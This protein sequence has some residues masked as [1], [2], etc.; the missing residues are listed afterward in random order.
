MTLLNPTRRSVPFGATGSRALRRLK[1][2]NGR[3]GV[4]E[5]DLRCMRVSSPLHCTFSAFN[6]HTEA[7]DRTDPTDNRPRREYWFRRTGNGDDGRM[8]NE[9]SVAVNPANG[10]AAQPT[11]QVDSLDATSQV[12]GQASN[13]PVSNTSPNNHPCRSDRIRPMAKSGEMAIPYPVSFPWGCSMCKTSATAQQGIQKHASSVHSLKA[14]F[15]CE[16]AGCKRQGMTGTFHSIA[17]HYPKCT[18]LPESSGAFHCEDCEATYQTKRGLSQHVRHRHPIQCNERRKG[19]AEREAERKRCKRRGEQF[20]DELDRNARARERTT[21]ESPGEQDSSMEARETVGSP[22]DR[23]LPL[24]DIPPPRATPALS[25]AEKLR[26]GKGSEVL[27]GEDWEL[28]L[29]SLAEDNLTDD[30]RMVE[31]CCER[32]LAL[33]PR[34]PSAKPKSRKDR[35]IDKGTEGKRVKKSAVFRRTQQLFEKN[36]AGL[37]REILDGKCMASCSLPPEEVEKLYET[38][39]S[40]PGPTVDLHQWPEP[41]RKDDSQLMTYISPNM[42]RNQIGRLKTSSASGPDGIRKTDLLKWDRYGYK[43]SALFNCWLRYQKVPAILKQNRSILI[44]KT[45]E[46]LDAIGNWRPL[47]IGPLPLRIFSSIMERRLRSCVHLHPRQRGFISSPG[48]EENLALV[49]AAIKKAKVRQNKCRTAFVTLDLAKAFDTISFDHLDKALER[50]GIQPPFRRLIQDMYTGATTV[51]TVRDG[52]TNPLAIRRGVKQGCPLSTSLF[53]IAMDPLVQA[54]SETKCGLET[55]GED[56]LS[57][58]AFADDLLVI[59]RSEGRMKTLLDM[60]Q[61]FVDAT[62]LT[63]N[64]EKCA[65]FTIEATSKTW[66]VIP[67]EYSLRRRK[68]RALEER[69]IPLLNANEQTKYLG[70][71]IGPWCGTEDPKSTRETLRDMIAQIDRYPGLKPTQRLDI[72]VTYAIPRLYYRLFGPRVASQNVLEGLDSIIRTQAKRWLHLHSSTANGLLYS[73]LRDGGLSLPYISRLVPRAQRGRLRRL[74]EHTDVAIREMSM[75]A[76]LEEALTKV[77]TTIALQGGDDYRKVEYERWKALPGPQGFG[78]A[79]YEGRKHSHN[80]INKPFGPK[81]ALSE[82]QWI[83]ALQ[84]RSNVYPTREALGRGRDRQGDKGCRFNCQPPPTKEDLFH[85]LCSCGGT[86]RKRVERHNYVVDLL[87]RELLD[88]GKFRVLKEQSYSVTQ[89]DGS[90]KTLKPDLVAVDELGKKG[91]ILDPTVVSEDRMA[92]S[93]EIKEKRYSPLIEKIK[94]DFSVNEVVVAGL[95]L[96][97]RGIIPAATVDTLSSIGLGGG[98]FLEK[99]VLAIVRGSL[100]A[101]SFSSFEDTGRIGY[102]SCPCSRGRALRH[103]PEGAGRFPTHVNL[104]EAGPEVVPINDGPTLSLA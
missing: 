17:C 21:R 35:C 98:A 18:P 89:E 62:G 104:P 50:S 45:K 77:V 10:Q 93:F 72:L 67:V 51:F 44:P 79:S 14:V 68:D 65:S 16:R 80:W 57:C 43:L 86:K 81:R 102:K 19:E 96:G 70:L 22:V 15:Y 61:K 13:L 3:A 59:A 32:L 47:T 20:E 71:K 52:E 24:N 30:W 23:V 31:E 73:R 92:E 12:P 95:V 101:V 103:V 82:S 56:Y 7:S 87:E 97:V 76:N 26:A 39:L 4:T 34:K 60:A 90:L 28:L 66:R 48:C 40:N 29:N 53:N 36:R 58:C 55:Q 88:Q 63:F 27:V 84:M 94:S 75:E 42:V 85:L 5:H 100:R 49:S 25:I 37:A 33:V 2:G 41:M 46:G 9:Q 54:L 1:Q 69:R 8:G 78:V 64:A 11:D 38:K 91:F 74:T 83:A 99:L 6:S